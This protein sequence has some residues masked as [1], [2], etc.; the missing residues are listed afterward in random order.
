METIHLYTYININI[1]TIIV[2]K[3]KSK[4]CHYDGF[5]FNEIPSNQNT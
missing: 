3:L 1:N 4:H 5:L 2:T